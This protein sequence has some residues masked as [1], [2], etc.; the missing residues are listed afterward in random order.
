MVRSVSFEKIRE[1]SLTSRDR[2][3]KENNK[4]KAQ[5][6][7]YDDILKHKLQANPKTMHQE[8]NKKEELRRELDE[9]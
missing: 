2:F 5:P 6:K 4:K 3:G 9:K 8:R 7:A 1:G